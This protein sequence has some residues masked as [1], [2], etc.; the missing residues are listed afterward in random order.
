MP[1]FVVFIFLKHGRHISDDITTSYSGLT[2]SVAKGDRKSVKNGRLYHTEETISSAHI[3]S[4]D[5]T[6]ELLSAYTPAESNYDN[7]VEGL[8]LTNSLHIGL[9]LP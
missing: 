8:S 7:C 5:P 6:H 2:H 9:Y 3:H 4:Y 1:L